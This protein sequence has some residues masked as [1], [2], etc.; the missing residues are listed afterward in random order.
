MENENIKVNNDVSKNNKA[1][2]TG[3][4]FIIG[5]CIIISTVGSTYLFTNYKLT[6]NNSISATGSAEVD[7]SS[8]LVVWRGNFKSSADSSTDAYKK[9]KEDSEIVKTYLKDNGVN[10][11]EVKFDS[12][13]ISEKT[14]PIWDN[15]GNWRGEEFAGYLL[16]QSVTI[17]STDLDKVDKISRDISSLLESGVEFTSYAPE[18]YCS[19]LDDVKLELI[20]KAT[21]NAK[22][23]ID[24]MANKSGATLGK[25]KSSK[26]GVFQIVAKNSGTKSY[27]Y[28]GY[29]DTS[30]KEKTANITVKLD[31]FAK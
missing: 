22:T 3:L 13:N 16:T 9:I 15:N 4:A 25:L 24:I 2:N 7:F 1:S 30:S 23:R 14:N 20:E 17:T 29:F 26:L 11:N 21:E 27:A 31:Y 6:I 28:D 19:K 10:D 18:Y 8:D 12:V 5:L